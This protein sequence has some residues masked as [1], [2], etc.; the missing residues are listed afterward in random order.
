MKKG[1]DPTSPMR[2]EFL[3]TCVDMG[4]SSSTIA[5]LTEP[6]K[7]ATEKE[8]EEIARVLLKIISRA[9]TEEEMLKMA[10]KS[11]GAEAMKRE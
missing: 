9:E 8:K 3:K 11:F 1:Y 6:M 4:I 2:Q 7:W 5:D 10:T